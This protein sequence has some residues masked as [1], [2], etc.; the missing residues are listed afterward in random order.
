MV[1]VGTLLALGLVIAALGSSVRVGL[2][3]LAAAGLCGV[4][5][6]VGRRTIKRGIALKETGQDPVAVAS[7]SFRRIRIGY[8]VALVIIGV[9]FGLLMMKSTVDEATL[10]FGG[11]K[12]LFRVDGCDSGIFHSCDGSL[13]DPRSGGLVG[14]GSLSTLA[15]PSDG[16]VLKVR[17]TQSSR[18]SKPIVHLESRSEELL[19]GMLVFLF[20]V[21]AVTGVVGLVIELRKTPWKHAGVYFKVVIG[22]GSSLMLIR[23]GALSGLVS[24]PVVTNA[25]LPVADTLQAREMTQDVFIGESEGSHYYRVLA[26]SGDS[27]DN[28]GT[29]TECGRGV[30]FALIDPDG[31]VVGMGWQLRLKWPEGAR[32]TAE[33]INGRHHPK[34]PAVRL[35]DIGPYPAPPHPE[36]EALPLPGAV[37]SSAAST[38][39]R[40]LGDD[41]DAFWFA[42]SIAADKV[43]VVAIFAAN[44]STLDRSPDHRDRVLS[45]L[46]DVRSIAAPVLD[47]TP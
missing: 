24:V 43:V 23:A 41:V 4:V 37:I 30:S 2:F 27:P 32:T 17:Q 36:A 42:R 25:A 21:M 34:I 12:R 13:F 1:T 44:G 16:S 40:P 46:A 14:G 38:P 20:P 8:F 10:S 22:V 15:T 3:L 19:T 6:F 11:P 18:D 29:V 5:I 9:G 7:R 28:C 47:R 35:E 39:Y 33:S 26:H 45:V 31:D